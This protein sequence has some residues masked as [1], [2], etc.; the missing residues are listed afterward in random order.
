M[1]NGIL[2]PVRAILS[3]Y[4]K[5]GIIDFAKALHGHGVELVSS[6]GTAK[7]ISDAGIPVIEVGDYTGAQEMFSGRVKT[8]HPK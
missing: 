7:A 4:D 8:L 5:A 6:G 3:V 2:K 1:T